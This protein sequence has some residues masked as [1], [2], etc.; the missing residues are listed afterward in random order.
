MYYRVISHLTV[1]A[2]P[3]IH[4]WERCFLSDIFSFFPSIFFAFLY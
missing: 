2:L 3:L 1:T 4:Q